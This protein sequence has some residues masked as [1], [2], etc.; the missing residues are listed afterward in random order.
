MRKIRKEYVMKIID[1]S[2]PLFSG[3]AVW[4]GSVELKLRRTMSISNGDGVNV[5]VLNMD[6]HTGTHIDAPLHFI[7][8]G[9]SVDELSL[10]TLCG[11]VY[12][13]EFSEEK[14]I[15]GEALALANIPSGTKR[16][17][18]KTKNSELWGSS[19][20][21]PEY[22]ALD[23]STAR[24]VVDSGIE[25]VGIDY[26]SIEQYE[27]GSEVHKILLGAGVV[28]IEG[29]N[30]NEAHPGSAELICL[31]LKLLGAEAAPARVVLRVDE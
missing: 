14:T 6:A 27:K 23:E 20:F 13:A 1:I 26:L 17:L 4:P 5:S 9:K 2:V 7:D 28:V 12:V 24:W 3:M 31:P 11:E 30:L 22:T 10:D 16:L 29:L 25:L 19:D 21:N 8:N 18:L 15:T